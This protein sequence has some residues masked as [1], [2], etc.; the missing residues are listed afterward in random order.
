MAENTEIESLKREFENAAAELKEAK[1]RDATGS[2]TTSSDGEHTT[3]WL[4]KK[5]DDLRAQ[6]L[7]RLP[8][9]KREAWIA[10]GA[11][12]LEKY[13]LVEESK[14]F[15]NTLL[16]K[17]AEILSENAELRKTVKQLTENPEVQEQMKARLEELKESELS[18]KGRDALDTMK[19]DKQTKKVSVVLFLKRSSWR[20]ERR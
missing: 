12:V 16:Q 3:E 17:G 6:I 14:E 11:G 2:D 13:G 9:D 18:K 15:T 1:E 10:Q 8:E 5:T 20:R 7:S 19:N 4:K